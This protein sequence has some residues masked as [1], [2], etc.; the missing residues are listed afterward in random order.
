M[1]QSSVDTPSDLTRRFTSPIIHIRVGPQRLTYYVHRDM[2]AL[3]SSFFREIFQDQDGQDGEGLVFDLD[4]DEPDL[5]DLFVRFMYWPGIVLVPESDGVDFEVR[6]SMLSQLYILGERFRVPRLQSKAVIEAFRLLDTEPDGDNVSERQFLDDLEIRIETISAIYTKT[7][8]DKD[9]F[10]RLLV[11]DMAHHWDLY[12]CRGMMARD[13]GEDSELC[14]FIETT[15]S[16][17]GD[18]FWYLEKLKTAKFG[19]PV[20]I[21]ISDIERCRS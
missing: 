3:K 4:N 1:S 2:I 20:G 6:L 13:D 12:S 9:S 7:A 11:T 17:A 16:F 19:L 15:P 21:R 5:I 8:S 14:R 18:L 10:R